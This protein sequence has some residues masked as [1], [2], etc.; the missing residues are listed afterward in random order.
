MVSHE[1]RNLFGVLHGVGSIDMY[2]C[3]IDIFHILVLLEYWILTESRKTLNLVL[4][5]RESL[6]LSINANEQ[7]Q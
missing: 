6:A 4:G 1:F 2:I 3:S 5:G 7:T